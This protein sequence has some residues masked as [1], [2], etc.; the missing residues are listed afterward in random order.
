MRK[1][2][3]RRV[4]AALVSATLIATLTQV[5][6]V[7]PAA[8]ASGP[9]VP[10][11]NTPSVPVTGQP[12]APRPQ[13]AAS[14][15]AISGDHADTPTKPG[16]S[17]PTATPLSPSSIWNV[18]EQTGDF[19]WSY[20]LRVP[21]APGSL[22]PDLAF[23]YT[24]A[25]IDGRTSA[26]NNQPSWVGDGWDLNPGFVERTY[27]GCA[28]DKEGS[29]KG[30]QVGDLCW[31]S[32]NATASY[33][34]GGGRLV[35]GAD[36]WKQEQDNGARIEK[37]NGA[38]NGAN[39]G[40]HWKITTVDGKQY[41]FGS[42]ADS[43]AAWTVP[44]YG[45][46]TGEPCNKPTF[47]ASA[48]TQAWR[49]MLDKV[50][51]THGNTIHYNYV[52]E[53]NKYGQNFKDT[54][55]S[56]VRNGYLSR[57]EYGL[58][59]AVTGQAPARVEFGTAERC[60][61][62]SNC[63]WTERGN[64]PDTPLDQ[65]CDTATCKDRYSP[66]FWTTKRLN[67]V[68][69][70][71]LKNG[72]YADV[73]RWE[74]NQQFPAPGSGEKPAL[75]LKAI[76]HVG[77]ASGTPI[78]LPPV[79]FEGAKMANR[80]SAGDNFSPILRYRLTG[81]VSEYG[82]VTSI[83]YQAADC[84]TKPTNPESNTRLCF[85][86]TWADKNYAERTD[87]FHKYVVESVIESDRISANPQKETHY[88]YV[89]GAAWHYDT[90]EFTPPDKKDWTEFRGFAKVLIR[91]G[92]QNDP[93]GPVTLT[94][95]RFFRG[96]HGDRLN[97][98]G[99]TKNVQAE[100]SES[101]KRNDD[102]WLAGSELESI[103]YDGSAVVSKKITQ[104]AVHG[105]TATKG[106][107][108]A[109][110]V[111]PGIERTYTTL[112]VGRRITES[113]TKYDDYGL[114]KTVDDQGDT[115]TAE[116]D[117]CT[118]T[119]YAR[120][121]AKHL[122][123]FTARE[124]TVAT[125]CGTPPSF[126]TD[127]ITDVRT[128]Y[129][130]QAPGEAP[131]AGN[132]T[133]DQRLEQRPAS[134]P[135]YTTVENTKYDVYGRATE[136]T[137]AEGKVTTTAYTPATGGPL[138]QVTV[139]NPLGHVNTTVMDPAYGGATKVID[140]N[141]RVTE[142]SYDALGR[143]S[144]VWLPNRARGGTSPQTANFKFSYDIHN[145]A[146]TVVTTTKLGP[147]GRYVTSNQLY[148]GLLRPRQ[149][150][151]PAL[152]GG[153]L[154]TDVRYDSQNR[155]AKSTQ[156]FFNSSP[157]DKTLSVASDNQVPGLT[158]ST[159]DGAGRPSASIF[160][161]AG[162][163]KWRTTTTYGG[164]RVSVDPPAGGTA[165]TTLLDAQGR[166]T[167]L[168]QYHGDS[169]TGGYDQTTYKYTTAG[170][171]AQMTDAPGNKWEY[172]Y[173]LRGRKTQT[174]DPDLGTT[175]LTYT[176]V[177]DVKTRTDARN[178]TLV[179]SYDD[180]GRR[181]AGY[182]GSL[183]GPKRI[184]WT[185]DKLPNGQE[186]KGQ[187]ATATTYDA[188][189]KSFTTTVQGYNALYQPLQTA[190]TVPEDGVAGDDRLAATYTTT[191]KYNVDG[192][193]ASETLPAAGGLPKE[194][195][196]HTYDDYGRALKTY[197]GMDGLGTVEYVQQTD[198][199]SYGEAQRLHLGENGKRAWLSYYYDDNTRQLSRTIVDA[200]LPKPMQSDVNYDYDPAGNITSVADTT[201]DRQPDVQCFKYDY[202]KRLTD[203]W[204]PS[205]GCESE[206][207]KAALTG[208]APYWQGWTYN[209]IGNRLSEQDHLTDVTR[210][211]TYPAAGQ[212]RPHAATAV[213]TQ[214]A[215]AKA[216]QVAN[217]FEYDAAGNTTTRDDQQL[218]WDAENRLTSSTKAGESTQFQYGSDGDRLVRSDSAT[219]TVYLPGQELQID[220]SSGD[221]SATRYYKHAGT[222]IG[223]RTG[224]VSGGA[225]GVATASS[226]LHWLAVDRQDTPTTAINAETQ[227]VVQ[228]RQLPF[229]ETR[230]A[231]PAFPGEKGFVGGT[232]DESTGLT[233][234]G[235]RE[236][237]AAQGRF[238]SVDPVLDAAD[239]QQV[240][241]YSYAGNNPITLSDPD[242]KCAGPDGI[243]CRSKWSKEG[244]DMKTQ[245]GRDKYEASRNKWVKNYNDRKEAVATRKKSKAE[246]RKRIVG[247]DCEASPECKR[248]TYL[249]FT[250]KG[251]QGRDMYAAALLNQDA[252]EDF[253]F[254]FVSDGCSRPAPD[255]VG[256][257]NA[258]PACARHDY[259]YRNRAKAPGLDNE[260]NRARVDSSLRDDLYNAPD[261]CKH[262]GGRGTLRDADRAIVAETYYF[263][264]RQAS[265]WS[266]SCKDWESAM[267]DIAE[268]GGF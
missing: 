184:A 146:P 38:S 251:A 151:T 210:S 9:S 240:Q 6:A 32:E 67:T 153:R 14:S 212:P 105:P 45:D 248:R 106:A 268:V 97:K 228:R 223:I 117:R 183:G 208:P 233:H 138:T 128:G 132:I 133:S 110:Q 49:W 190:L 234:L 206:P 2:H 73:E 135:V 264:V 72:A 1:P 165:T 180:L 187:Q 136:S 137:D 191:Y 245:Q 238:I 243:G 252:W 119:T 60:L 170:Q 224:E 241:G 247:F 227:S 80:V 52:T 74:L 51:D 24:S 267:R 150:Q 189:G 200:E 29:N 265:C 21:P 87:Y 221:V 154:L 85:P 100:D 58:N 91:Q 28:A 3:H 123:A 40:E 10:L 249:A 7:Q 20:P 127:A 37:L 266:Q 112:P 41:F 116:D 69:T 173:D 57:I 30:E 42:R 185:Y 205:G 157:V 239:P 149:T 12:M 130:S 262:C 192:S 198:Y 95:K 164:D 263:V 115:A 93:A 242:G 81:I 86:A 246:T 216:V 139:T 82:G 35:L 124:E 147:T 36:G 152:G 256:G 54:G 103:T 158:V 201:L 143:R 225:R 199:T 44:V 167:A 159:Y 70:Q 56:Y 168:R 213:T 43:A 175:N 148:D 89:D 169:P 55:V 194:S 142:T 76:N 39:E 22:Q 171:L 83:N 156:A 96:M 61:P 101:V 218:A 66:S 122:I 237:D 63:V 92:A 5:I 75:W 102:D 204:T 229:G 259:G 88:Q 250:A 26:T 177:D 53:L 134:G 31:R 47:A 244:Y 161:G 179:Y 188:N 15:D 140:P 207:S 118:T 197:G 215:G 111:N 98:L 107:L 235:A 217:T 120:N 64:F 109:Y 46:D 261:N 50:V 253:D 17:T 129:D 71:V 163:E 65:L 193:L 48:C 254:D 8:A 236:Y 211:Y 90:S 18:S 260:D 155:V 231:A 195:V 33:P 84:T 121:T 166:T 79:T 186:V 203:A 162:A 114:A 196:F 131:V 125:R 99:G 25:A 214:A 19:T 226:S 178:Q 16:A 141:G 68:T 257:L 104:Q 174:K 77:L 13:D 230:G 11:P 181:T 258:V 108:N 160:Q 232:V 176:A 202:L 78:T 59:Q 126:P 62:G 113:E 222:T 34:G 4:L 27:G 255:V 209:S 23:S 144:E 94:E 220:R 219:A 145:D 182:L 172:R